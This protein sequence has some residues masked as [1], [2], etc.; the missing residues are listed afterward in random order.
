MP[1]VAVRAEPR[2]SQD[3]SAFLILMLLAALPYL[4]SLANS[5]VYDDRPQILENP[6]VHSFRYLGRIFGST[7]W[8]FEGAQG[9]SNYYRP[10]M[11]VAY[12]VCYRTFGRL[13]YGFHL[14]NVLLHI[15]IVLL[16]F[17]V[18]E[19]LFGDRLLS[20]I[21]AGLFALHPI[22][23]ESVAWIAGITDL[24]LSFFFLLTFLLYLRLAE[25]APGAAHAWP[26]CGLMLIA[27]LLGLLSKEQ[28]L[29]FPALALVYEHFYRPGRE[30][31]SFRAKWHRYLPLCLTVAAYLAF[32]RLAL[33]SFAPAVSRPTLPWSSV[34]LNAIA[35]V[36]GYLGKL[37]WPVH[38]TAFYVFHES[39]SL[40][41]P[42][43]LAGLVGLILCAGLF[44]W[45][46][47]HAHPVS[48]AFLWMGATLA[49]V[50]NARWMPAQVFAERYLYLPSIGFC[51][52][53]AWAA[54]VAWRKA[55]GKSARGI[56][57]QRSVALGLV[58]V[59]C[60]YAVATVRRNRDWRT[61]E[62]LYRRTLAAQPD[63]QLIH[64]NLG[65]VYSDRG[66]WADAERE[67]T[68]A[69][70]PGKPYAPTLNNLGL[71]RKNQRRY[72]E[73]ADLFNQ[74]IALRPKY[75]DPYKN[76]AEMYVETGRLDDADSKFT[77][78]V[79]LA[80]L[81]TDV[82]NSYGHFL[83]EHGRI[84]EA[85]EQFARSAEAD[86][87]SEACDNLGDLALD[88]GDLREA[89]TRYAAS[90]AVNQFDNRA[91]FGL[92]TLDERQ[93][94]IAEALREYRAGLETDPRN[95]IA[96]DAVHRLADHASQ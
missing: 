48:F 42:R 96:L 83:L 34:F 56:F 58:V 20:L 53:V 16:L 76:L 66:D 4:N 82:R 45:L 81:D 21:A 37:V 55:D 39:H 28:A 71:L 46:W 17:L 69:L 72:S 7:V 36:G 67:W 49:P 12:L 14:L 44:V 41:E 24:E 88:A 59:A 62:V 90:L 15:A 29:V 26:A 10:L 31:T 51:W 8:S 30:T 18:T 94:R 85:R 89:R 32:R 75:V 93:G 5:F 47:R 63:A 52:L 2:K 64:T 1:K 22:H 57:L 54:T 80:P 91:Y 6:Y 95:P 68:L 35:L 25:S 70:G 86:A 73:A 60:F 9:V 74:A 11:T 13:P 84:T 43:V 87:N 33:G 3:P 27:Y 92:A 77:Q 38:L 79:A 23:T 65:V 78:A 19:R 61:D 50:L 40:R